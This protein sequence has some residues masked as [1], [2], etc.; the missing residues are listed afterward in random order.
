MQFINGGVLVTLDSRQV[1]RVINLLSV[2][3]KVS[4]D[5]KVVPCEYINERQLEA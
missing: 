1:Y 4:D 5:T 3:M 2:K